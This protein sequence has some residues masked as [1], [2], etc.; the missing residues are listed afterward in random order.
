MPSYAPVT[1]PAPIVATPPQRV[2]AMVDQVADQIFLGL[3]KPPIHRTSRALSSHLILLLFSV[4][5]GLSIPSTEMPQPSQAIDLAEAPTR[6]D[7][8]APAKLDILK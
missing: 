6:R 5:I 1:V 3:A 7:F 8:E 4:I 2:I